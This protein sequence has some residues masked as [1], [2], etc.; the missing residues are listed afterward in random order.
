METSTPARLPRLLLIRA[1][2]ECHPGLSIW[3]CSMC[4][5]RIKHK[6]LHSTFIQLS[7]TI[8]NTYTTV[9]TLSSW[10]AICAPWRYE[11]RRHRRTNQFLAFWSSQRSLSPSVTNNCFSS[12]A[13]TLAVHRCLH[14]LN[15]RIL[16]S[17]QIMFPTLLSLQRTKIRV[18]DRGFVNLKTANWQGFM[19]YLK[20]KLSTTKSRTY[21]TTGMK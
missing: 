20:H 4:N 13:I 15:A 14:V 18:S 11:K 9:M 1:G 8:S 3:L 10:Q 7:S 21:A 2:I 5:E 17:K 6:S 16:P 12:P 19:D